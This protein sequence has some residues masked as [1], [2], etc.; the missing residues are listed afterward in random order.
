[1]DIGS[2]YSDYLK[3]TSTSASNLER[4]LAGKGKSKSDDE[5]LEA[6]KQFE[7]YYY[8]QVFKG[9]EK[10]M[11]P[12]DD[13]E[14]GSTLVDYYKEQLISQYSSQVVEQSGSGSLANKLYEQMKRNN[15]IPNIDM[16]D[17]EARAAEVTTQIASKDE[18][19]SIDNNSENGVSAVSEV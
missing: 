13:S 12:K 15:V 5:L 4:S 14:A 2:L 10:A 19:T 7:T 17:A 9:M 11:V 6:C 1:M 18:N 8:E 3:S 16:E